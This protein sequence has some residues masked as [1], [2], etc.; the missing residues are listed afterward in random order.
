VVRL[1][2]KRKVD[3]IQVFVT[4]RCKKC[5]FTTNSRKEIRKHVR[6]V[7]KIKGKEWKSPMTG[8][9]KKMTP[10]SDITKSYERIV[11]YVKG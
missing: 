1:K 8:E 6:E 4:Y 3:T 9:W 7:H 10:I 5:G 11:E 2:F